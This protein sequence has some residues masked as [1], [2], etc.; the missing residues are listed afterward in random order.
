MDSVVLPRPEVSDSARQDVVVED[1]LPPRDGADEAEATVSDVSGSDRADPLDL[2]DDARGLADA[3]EVMQLAERAGL[4]V[5]EIAQAIVHH[6]TPCPHSAGGDI[7]TLPSFSLL[8]PQFYAGDGD[9][10]AAAASGWSAIQQAND[11]EQFFN[12]GGAPVWVKVS[13]HDQAV[14]EVLTVSRMQYIIGMVCDC[15]K[16]TKAGSQPCRPPKSVAEHLVAE[17]HPPLPRLRRITRVPVFDDHGNLCMKPGYHPA[18][19]LFVATRDLV[20]P[21]VSHFPS[22]AD[23]DIALGLLLDEMLFDFP[24]VDNGSDRTNAVALLLL[25]FVR[26]LIGGPTPLHL[27]TK[28]GVGTGATLLV[29][30]LLYPALGEKPVMQPLPVGEAEVQ[31]RITAA[32]LSGIGAIIFDNIPQG[33]RLASEQLAGVLTA[34]TWGDRAI[35]SS[36]FP[37]IPIT[38]A[39]VATGNNVR[40]SEEI[41]RRTIPIWLDAKMEKPFTRTG[42][43]LPDI[44]AWVRDNRS[45]VVWAALTLVQRWVSLGMPAG[46]VVKGKYEAWARVL[47]GITEMVGLRGLD[48]NWDEWFG[49]IASPEQAYRKLVALWHAEFSERELKVSELLPVIGAELDIDPFGGRASETALGK[50][51]KS[52]EGR[53]IDGY[54]IAGRQVSGSARWRLRCRG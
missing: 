20:V 30:V 43:R 23:V 33:Q 53:A 35:R 16:V 10:R 52:L 19:G 11:P 36:E 4:D 18:S 28:P 51:L 48:A 24:F 42:F 31:R 34:S 47:S 29:E 2:A 40:S 17:P 44:E 13:P 37:C 25:P 41:A 46:S 27:F 50:R 39:W 15:Y 8:R 12:F 49:G 1:E 22:A 5:V 21:R 45:E 9:I 32:L 14:T 38:N 3:H 54:E 6:A 7:G 26:D